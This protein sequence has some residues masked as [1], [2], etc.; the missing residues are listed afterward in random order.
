MIQKE[1]KKI[2]AFTKASKIKYLGT[3]VT[4]EV[5]DLYTESYKNMAAKS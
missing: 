3:N 4:K 5:K 2:T 1:I